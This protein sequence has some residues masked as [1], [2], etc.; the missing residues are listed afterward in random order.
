M[1]EC[2]YMFETLPCGYASARL[3]ST[4]LQNLLIILS[5]NSPIMFIPELIYYAQNYSQKYVPSMYFGKIFK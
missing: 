4:M 1:M 3:K 5:G 2:S